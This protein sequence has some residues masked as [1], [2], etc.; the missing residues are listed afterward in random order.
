MNDRQ[1]NPYKNG[2]NEQDAK[3]EE[4]EVGKDEAHYRKTKQENELK[5]NR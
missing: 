1:P 2:G 3:E 4:E 5:W